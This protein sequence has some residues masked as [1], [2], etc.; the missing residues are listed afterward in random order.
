MNVAPERA[1]V[2]PKF[3]GFFVPER[4]EKPSLGPHEKI[5]VV[6]DLHGAKGEVI[7]RL[8]AIPLQ[9]EHKPAAVILAGDVAGNTDLEELQKPFYNHLTNHTKNDLLKD[10][11][12]SVS[13]NDLLSYR[14]KKP[15]YEGYTVKKGFLD[16]RRKELE[17]EGYAGTEI[18]D[19]LAKLSDRDI[20]DTI[21]KYAKYGHYGHYASNLSE[22]AVRKLA[23]GLRENA[24]ALA[25][26]LKVLRD[27]KV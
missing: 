19:S 27:A 20:S 25:E 14:G 16:L 22:A 2:K 12:V 15:P 11:N 4:R 7:N 21:R 8:K 6:S 3:E 23:K 26:P 10:P 5:I 9:G 13:D 24:Q 17:L 1:S 18:E